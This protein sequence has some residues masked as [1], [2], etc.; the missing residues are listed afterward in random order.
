MESEEFHM[1]EWLKSYLSE[2]NQ[3]TVIDA[4]YNQRR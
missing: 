3:I 2:I 4:W 1:N